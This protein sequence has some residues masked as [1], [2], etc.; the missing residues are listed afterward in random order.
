MFVL[1]ILGVLKGQTS[2]ACSYTVVKDKV[3]EGSKSA[4][5][6]KL[7]NFGYIVCVCLR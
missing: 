2:N 3:H 7:T 1:D 4:L 5:L 6:Q